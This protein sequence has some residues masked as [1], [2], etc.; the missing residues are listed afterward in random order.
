MHCLKAFARDG[1]R[2][3]IYPNREEMGHRAGTDAAKAIAAAI[4]ERGFANVLFAAAPS[5]NETLATLCADSRVDWTKVNAFH[6]DEYIGLPPSHPAGF[7]QYLKRTIFDRFP[8][9]SVHLLGGDA[10]D[11]SQEIARYEGLLREYPLDVCLMG[12]G[13]NGHIAFN[14]PPV[15]DFEDPHLVKIVELEHRCRMQQVHDGCFETI[16]QVPTHALTVTIPGIMGAGTLVCSVPAAT[17]A[18]AARD[19]MLGE[20]STA[21]PASVLRRHPHAVLYLDRASGRHLL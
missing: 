3:L 6:M 17:K 13:E 1:L 9:R 16:D 8:F 14:D 18:E 10:Q 4:A 12:I 19:I 2:V 11:L 5:Q 20:I 21:C 15:A 7:R